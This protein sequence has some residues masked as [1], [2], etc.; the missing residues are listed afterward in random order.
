MQQLLATKNLVINYSTKTKLN[1]VVWL[2][3]SIDGF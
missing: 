1:T 3:V 2:S